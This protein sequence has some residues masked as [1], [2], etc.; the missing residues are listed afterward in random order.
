MFI[1]AGG[2][3]VLTDPNG[4]RESDTF[5]CSHCSGIVV[6]AAC[7]RPEDLGGMCKRCMGLICPKCVG[8]SCDPI[9]ERLRRMEN[10]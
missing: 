4:R 7:E 3:A 1:R 9:E 5:T 6:V 2:Y 8:F 10:R